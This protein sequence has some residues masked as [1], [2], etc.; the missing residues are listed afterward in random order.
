MLKFLKKYWIFGLMAPLFMLGEVVMDLIQSQ[1]MRVIIDEGVLGL[2]NNGT[3]NLYLIISMGIKMIG[4][5]ILGGI[6]GVLSGVFANVFSQNWGNDIRKAAFKR[7][8]EFS[9]EQTD[10]FSTGS[11]VTRITDE[12][13]SSVDTRT[14]KHIQDAMVKLMKD[15]TSLI[16]AHRLST[17]QDADLIVVMDKGR[18]AETGNHSEL[19]EKRGKYY[20]LY[21]TQFEGNAI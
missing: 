8:M 17:I 5:V 6:S 13:T 19:I 11:L 21:R 4:I 12:A 1:M 7:V 10:K 15:R 3:G 16:I 2:S 18:I 14:E 9:F 20:E